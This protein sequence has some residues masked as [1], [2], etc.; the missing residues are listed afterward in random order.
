M[1]SINLLEDFCTQLAIVLYVSIGTVSKLAFNMN[2]NG[3]LR[4]D[5]NGSI[6]VVILRNVSIFVLSSLSWHVLG[7]GG[8]REPPTQHP[9]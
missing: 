8:G 4:P 2:S 9:G 7:G 1:P 3:S 5:Q 6:F